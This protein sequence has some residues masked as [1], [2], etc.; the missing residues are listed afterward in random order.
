MS[1]ATDV[2][3][4]ICTMTFTNIESI[5]LL[6]GFIRNNY[7]IVDNSIVLSIENPKIIRKI[8]SMLKETFEINPVIVQGKAI[9]FNKK[10]YYNII[11]NDKVSYILE[12]LNVYMNGKKLA[13][14]ND[15]FVDSQDL[16]RA[17]L[18]GVFLAVGSINDPKKSRYHL[19]F[20][21]DNMDEASYIISILKQFNI[22]AKVISRDKGFMVYVKEAEKIGDF[23]RIISVSR[24]VM[25][26]EDI[27]IYRDHKNMTN[28]LNN[29]EQANVDKIISSSNNQINDINLIVEKLGYEVI[30]EKLKEVMVYR[31]KYPESS[32]NELS[33]IITFE[34]GKILTK[35]G[36]NHRMRKIHEM[37]DKLRK[38]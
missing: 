15:Y 25:Y 11:I 34:T 19:E 26:Y 9:N 37:A 12:T 18:A 30:D 35:S 3:N 4:E 33:E 27:R 20:L 22:N 7:E 6:S 23:L 31:L 1:F 8:F 13:V 16:Y 2:K 29:C 14:P 10:S 24:A 28:R 21:L 17:Y 5:V 32:L 36:I 38:K